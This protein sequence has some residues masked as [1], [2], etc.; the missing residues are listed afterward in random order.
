MQYAHS[1]LATCSRLLAVDCVWVEPATS[2]LRVR[3]STNW[4]TALTTTATVY[5]HQTK[6]PILNN[7]HIRI[8]HKKNKYV[9]TTGGFPT[10]PD[11]EDHPV[12]LVPGEGVLVNKRL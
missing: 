9:K 8:K 3:Y 12:L 6:M 7:T 5:L 4:T 10:E 11:K 2:R 1:K